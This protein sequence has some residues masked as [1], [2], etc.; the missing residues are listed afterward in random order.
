V[1]A[2]EFR[3]ASAVITSTHIGSGRDSVGV[4]TDL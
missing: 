2:G 1:I 4:K 3:V